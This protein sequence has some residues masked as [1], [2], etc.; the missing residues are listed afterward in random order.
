MSMLEKFRAGARKAQLQAA[1]FVQEGGSRV[2][3]ESAALV[4]GFSLPGEAEK[5]AKI[6]ESFLGE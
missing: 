4:R 1:A 5:A 3:Q 6:L 2:Q